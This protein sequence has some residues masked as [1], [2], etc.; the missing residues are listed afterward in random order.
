MEKRKYLAGT[1]IELKSTGKRAFIEHTYKEAFGRGSHNQISVI[2]LDDDGN[3]ECSSAWSSKSDFRVIKSDIE[4]NLKKIRKYNKKDDG[5]PIMMNPDLARYLGYTSIH[6]Y[7]SARA[8][9]KGS[10]KL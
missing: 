10:I 8:D 2:W 1:L 6:T 4:A 7:E 5:A 3:I 9:R